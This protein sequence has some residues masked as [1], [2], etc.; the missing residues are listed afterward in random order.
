MKGYY[1]V[2]NRTSYLSGGRGP[3]L[4]LSGVALLFVVVVGCAVNDDTGA[5]QQPRA[6]GGAVEQSGAASSQARPQG[7]LTGKAALGDWTTDA[8]GVRR[9]IT[10]ADLPRPFDTKSV[11]NGPRLVSRPEG[12]W[13]KAPAG[14]M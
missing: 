13:P 3:R 5:Q 10:A 7:V 12:A 1:Q 8:P 2:M 9:R 6:D 11:D 4:A 14:G